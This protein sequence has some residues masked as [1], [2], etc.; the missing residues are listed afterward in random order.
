MRTL[1]A[2]LLLALLASSCTPEPPPKPAEPP[3]PV[4]QVLKNISYFDLGMFEA[5]PPPLPARV[6]NEA[7][8]G[9]ELLGR[10]FVMECLVDAKNRGPDAKSKVV[11]DSKL[12][13]AG[14]EHKVTGDNLTPAGVACVEA[15]LA[16]WTAASPG[17]SAKNA[18]GPAVAGHVEFQHVVG[19]NPAV[20][21]GINDVS[22]IA[23]AVRLA[24]PTWGDCFTDWKGAAP[25]PVKAS[26]KVSRPVPPAAAAAGAASDA[27]AADAKAAPAPVAAEVVPAEIIFEANPDPVATKVAACLKTKLGALKVKT[28]SGESVTLPY[29]FHFVNSAITA[30]LPSALPDVQFIQLDLQRARRAAEAAIV[31]GTRMQ[32]VG[33]YDSAVQTFKESKGKKPTLPELKE[34]CAAL[35]AA[36]DQ[37]IGAVEKQVAQEEATQKFTAAQKATDPSWADADA[38]AGRKLAEAQKDLETFKGYRKGDEGAC[39]KM[40]L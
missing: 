38:A 13:D 40:K 29:A 15:A 1:N 39:P 33:V 7:L 4:Q 22:D 11:V 32:A 5:A 28:P 19:V 26:I 25:T 14:V 37:M 6:G 27:K 18:A 12:T 31:L 2:S 16:K 9:F 36:D 3:K 35:L 24:M 20:V 23:A 21:M 10:P 30:T 34:K 17:L 8:I